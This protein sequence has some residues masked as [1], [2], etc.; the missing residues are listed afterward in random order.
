MAPINTSKPKIVY[1]ADR[2]PILRTFKELE[3]ERARLV[4]MILFHER[5]ADHDRHELLRIDTAIA[6]AKQWERI[7]VAIVE[8]GE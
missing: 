2:G 8:A 4:F 1:H 5:E 3:V 7:D 6:E